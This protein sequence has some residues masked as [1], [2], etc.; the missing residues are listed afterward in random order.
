MGLV[1]GEII[2]ATPCDLR[3]PAVGERSRHSHLALSEREGGL[4]GR[5]TL[6]GGP[7]D[8]SPHP[9][10]IPSRRTPSKHEAMIPRRRPK[11]VVMS[12]QAAVALHIGLSRGCRSS[13]DCN[14]RLPR[15]IGQSVSSSCKLFSR[16][17]FL[18]LTL[19]TFPVVMVVEPGPSPLDNK[20]LL[21]FFSP[22]LA[23]ARETAGGYRQNSKFCTDPRIAAA[24]AGA[25][26]GWEWG[27]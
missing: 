2:H 21:L 27:P 1:L 25:E 24:R 12:S 15:H 9:D 26:T 17:H 16:H 6:Q 20:F 23:V 18:N 3:L 11:K 5:A 13:S 10:F 14:S 19:V 8:S 22:S 4:A 7:R